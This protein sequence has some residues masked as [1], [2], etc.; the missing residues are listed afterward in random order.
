MSQAV[1]ASK[2]FED[3]VVDAIDETLEREGI[4]LTEVSLIEQGTADMI[5][6]SADSVLAEGGSV[7]DLQDAISSAGVFSAERSLRIARTI[8]GSA[9]SLGQMTAG[10]QS[11]ATAK[12]WLDSG[13]NV[14]DAHKERNGEKVGI[15]SRFS[16]K[17]G[18]AVGPRWPGDPE[19]SAADRIQCRCSLTFEA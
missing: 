4:I 1:V 17:L 12:V 19:I 10:A 8:T 3:D 18:S 11:G 15:D 16:V 6:A 14:R 13:S 9:A 7:A 5:I 2:A